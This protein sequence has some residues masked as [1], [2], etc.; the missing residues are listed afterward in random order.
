MADYKLV[1][2]KDDNLI[3]VIRA[4]D[5]AYIPIDP[6]IEGDEDTPSYAGN[7]DY[8]AY[9]SWSGT[10]DA[11]DPAYEH[12]W[13]YIRSRRDQKLSS[14]DWTQVTD[15]QISGSKVTEFQTYRQDLRDVPQDFATPSGVIWPTEPSLD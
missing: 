15:V 7:R 6:K 14:T 10:A 11:A 8:I 1:K 13:E 12:T 4:S 5:G 3:G 9:L 2:D